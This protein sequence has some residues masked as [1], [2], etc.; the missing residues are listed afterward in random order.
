MTL[1]SDAF[2]AIVRREIGF[3]DQ[4]ENAVGTLTT[5]LSDDSR[6]V[7]KTSGVSTARQF[8]AFLL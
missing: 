6:L 1:R 7:A 2:E 5:R 3:F 8:Q 4:E